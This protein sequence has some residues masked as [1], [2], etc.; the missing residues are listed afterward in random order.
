[1]SS[2]RVAIERVILNLEKKGFK[3]NSGK[4][5]FSEGT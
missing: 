2:K 3:K 1:M 4:I 5:I